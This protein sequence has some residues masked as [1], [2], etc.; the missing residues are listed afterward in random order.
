MHNQKSPKGVFP[1]IFNTYNRNSTKKSTHPTQAK[2]RLVATAP[3]AEGNSVFGRKSARSIMVDLHKKI[4]TLRN[5]PAQWDALQQKVDTYSKPSA[6]QVGNLVIQNKF[7]VREM[8]PATR[9]QRILE[10]VQ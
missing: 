1:D 7:A 6:S 10:K 3:P 4:Q 9:M 5:N 2:K 8:A